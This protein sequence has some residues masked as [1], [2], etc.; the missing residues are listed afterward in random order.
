[1]VVVDT[2]DVHKKSDENG[3]NRSSIVA[4]ANKTKNNPTT[5]KIKNIVETKKYP[6]DKNST[7]G[8]AI[9]KFININLQSA[10]KKRNNKSGSKNAS[11]IVDTS[12]NTDCIKTKPS[13]V[14]MTVREREEDNEI[15]VVIV[16]V[17]IGAELGFDLITGV[18]AFFSKAG[19]TACCD[20]DVYLGPL[21]MTASIPF[22]FLI[23]TEI[24]FL[25]RAILTSTWHKRMKSRNLN[26]DFCCCVST[27][28]SRTL[29]G[30]L[31]CMT[32]INPFFGCLI[33]Y[34]LLYQSDKTQSFSVLGIEFLSIVVHIVAVKMVG[35][36][37]TCGSKV[38]HSIV[39]IPFLITIVFVSLFIREGGMCYVVE[40]R[41]FGY[42]GCEICPITMRPPNIDGNCREDMHPDGI[43]GVFGE[44]IGSILERG[45]EQGDYCSRSTNFCFFE[46]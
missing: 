45:V 7:S 30:Y 26:D 6:D 13:S 37:Q 24:T 39:F 42:S 36:L 12:K 27:W 4:K 34:I 9:P 23:A 16:A 8:K 21:A 25:I 22:F 3:A 44:G 29:L 15:N 20:H 10:G 11:E 14:L 32:I 1:M 28:T 46:F 2:V 33:A 31:N 38:V 41:R 19:A 18:I 40:T 17:M 43:E 5:K 35:G